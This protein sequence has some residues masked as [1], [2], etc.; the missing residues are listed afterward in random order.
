MRILYT[1]RVD[2]LHRAAVGAFHHNKLEEEVRRRG[3][4][5][6][7]LTTALEVEQDRNITLE[8]G[9]VKKV[10]LGRTTP[11]LLDKDF[12]RAVQK[13][14]IQEDS[15]DLAIF[16]AF[17]G[18]G[19]KPRTLGINAAINFLHNSW[20]TMNPSRIATRLNL[21]PRLAS[22]KNFVLWRQDLARLAREQTPIAVPS[23][24]TKSALLS[25]SLRG[26][27]RIASQQVHVVHNGLPEADGESGRHPSVGPTRQGTVL[28]SIGRIH[29]QKGLETLIRAAAVLRDRGIHISVRINGPH[30][31][32]SYTK[33]LML[34]ASRLNIAPMVSIGDGIPNNQV[35]AVWRKSHFAAFPSTFDEGLSFALLEAMQAGAV[36]IASRSG[37]NVE[38]LHGSLDELLF[39]KRDY[40]GLACTVHKL[41]LNPQRYL[42]LQNLSRE[43]IAAEFVLSRHLQALVDA[44][45]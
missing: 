31:D 23:H 24:F 8:E 4:Q 38:A 9:D 3:W 10:F 35:P 12:S 40:M 29:P 13:F 45:A 28:Q 16:S 18:V 11:D 26:G 33:S 43:R 37:G 30:Q 5:M 44:A 15:F 25:D 39:E 6:T 36:P 19:L 20:S 14:V 2:P 17:S 1:N 21:R 41:V 7:L 22:A 32:P 27:I 42:E 34:L